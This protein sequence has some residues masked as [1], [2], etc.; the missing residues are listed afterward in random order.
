MEALALLEQKVKDLVELA[1]L[2]KSELA[3]LK[4]ANQLLAQN[5]L[6]KEKE[7]ADLQEKFL[8]LQHENEQ[9]TV[10]L[11]GGQQ[12]LDH[13]K[14]LTKMFVDG[15]LKNIESITQNEQ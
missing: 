13:E 15:L 8:Q 9:L 1:R 7:C 5:L 14:E 3:Q 6:D 10:S 12:E 11:A 4:S 2:Q